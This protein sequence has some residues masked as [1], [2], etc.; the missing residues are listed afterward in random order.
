MVKNRPRAYR[1]R[2]NSFSPVIA[3]T[4]S[5][6]GV[7]IIMGP[8]LEVV[9]WTTHG[10][11]TP[12]V[13]RKTRLK[14]DHALRMRGMRSRVFVLLFLAFVTAAPLRSAEAQNPALHKVNR[15]HVADMGT[16]AEAQRFHHLLKEELQRGGFSVAEGGAVDDAVLSGE[17]STEVQ[18]DRSFARVT[19]LL[20]SPDRK[21]TLWSGDFISQH[22]GEG[23][24]DVVKTLAETCA[25]RLRK[26]WQKG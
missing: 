11:R 12:S 20:K 2:Q 24:E 7:T 14:Q 6:E 15:I 10:A 23:H 9:R 26:E 21:R 17:L 22:K 18:G 5:E 19:V 4:D 25:E 8:G 13:L 1:G 16:G 3:A